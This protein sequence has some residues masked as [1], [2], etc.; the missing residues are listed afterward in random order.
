MLS[1]F[2]SKYE[3]KISDAIEVPRWSKDSL[4]LYLSKN[5]GRKKF[6]LK[7]NDSQDEKF[8]VTHYLTQNHGPPTRDMQNG[9][10]PPSSTQKRSLVDDC[11]GESSQM[12]NKNKE[13]NGHT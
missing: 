6:L 11:N 5:A 4:N 2:L 9:T 10:I 13:R 7:N 12:G 1:R 8:K 3:V